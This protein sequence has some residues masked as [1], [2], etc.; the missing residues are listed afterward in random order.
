MND[1]HALAAFK[2]LDEGRLQP[3]DKDGVV[4]TMSMVTPEDRE[5]ARQWWRKHM[6][7]GQS[8]DLA[9]AFARHRHQSE[10]GAALTSDGREALI[11]AGDEN[12]NG[13]AENK[14]GG[15]W[16]RRWFK[17]Q[18]RVNELE[19]LLESPPQH[20]FWGAGEPECPREI[21]A[22]NGELH[23]L[24]C[25]VCG[26]DNPRDDLCRAQRENEG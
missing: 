5:A 12:P 21:K 6:G 18:E 14:A 24:R 19:R 1:L 4:V 22:S 13:V 11:E 20:R 3:V 9:I 7:L 26:L 2:A 8:E 25:K 15:L 16:Y 17:A 10:T 23:T